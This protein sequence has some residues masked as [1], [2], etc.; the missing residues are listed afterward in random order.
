MVRIRL[1]RSDER[2]A[3][4]GVV[5]RAAVAYRGVIPPDCWHEPYMA[6]ADLDREIE[7]G[8]SFW[9]YE[10]GGA[11]VGVMGLQDVKDVAL[12]RHAYVEPAQQGKG[13]GAALLA[14]LRTLTARRILIGTWADAAWAIRFYQRH[15]F[16]LTS[17]AEKAALLRTYWTI[18][19][20]QVET[21]VVL[22]S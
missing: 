20:R 2:D 4:H 3:I 15:G 5:N 18:S 19:D 11:L 14:H 12:I 8:V 9:G 17:A 1:C 13:V 22:T 7:A 10:D 21:S 16:A 6:R